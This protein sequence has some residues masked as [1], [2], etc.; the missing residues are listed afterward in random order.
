MTKQ[1]ATAC[2]SFMLQ[3]HYRDHYVAVLAPLFLRLFYFGA[4]AHGLLTGY[5]SEISKRVPVEL[6]YLGS[7]ACT[8]TRINKGTYS[9]RNGLRYPWIC[10][11]A[12]VTAARVSSRTATNSG[13]VAW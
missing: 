3:Q 5:A 10:L 6:S 9:Q 8:Q 4:V 2:M 12:A 1:L 7:I 11:G 13:K